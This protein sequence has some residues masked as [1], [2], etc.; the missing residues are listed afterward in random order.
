MN[1]MSVEDDVALT[2]KTTIQELARPLQDLLGKLLGPAASEVGNSL[3]DSVKVW[4]FGRQ[5]HLLEQM[6]RM[7]E[8]SG[9]DVNPV[10]PRLFFPALEAATIED[11]DDMQSRW[12]ALLANEA[13]GTGTFHP[14][15]IEMLKQ[16]APHD[17]RL[18][19]KLYDFCESHHTQ[20]IEWW[21]K[22]D[23]APNA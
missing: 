1:H 16:W 17:A 9:N 19:D 2:I 22:S 15:Y 14:S 12:A 6:K 5:I 10:A 23:P 11:D 18:L 20:R 7:I 8:E 4:R 3:G 13:T 21:W